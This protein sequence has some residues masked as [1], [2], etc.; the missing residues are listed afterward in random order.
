MLSYRRSD[1]LAI[2]AMDERADAQFRAVGH[3]RLVRRCYA[4][5]RGFARTTTI[6]WVGRKKGSK[7]ALAAIH[8]GRYGFQRPLLFRVKKRTAQRRVAQYTIYLCI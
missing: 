2:A 4:D 3:S 5:S 8:K 1:K 7:A 6:P